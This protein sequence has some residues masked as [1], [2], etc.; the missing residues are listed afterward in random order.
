[1]LFP[2]LSREVGV[3]GRSNWSRTRSWKVTEIR[4]AQGCVLFFS[5]E[6]WR[7]FFSHRNGTT[8]QPIDAEIGTQVLFSLYLGIMYK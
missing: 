7:F 2:H 4:K 3:R 6:F 1:M 5:S 8:E